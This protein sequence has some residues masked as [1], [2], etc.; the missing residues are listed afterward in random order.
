MADLLVQLAVRTNNNN[1]FNIRKPIPEKNIH[2]LTT[3]LCGYYTTS[4]TFSILYG[5]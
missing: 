5:P 3:C 2:S 1:S 4:L